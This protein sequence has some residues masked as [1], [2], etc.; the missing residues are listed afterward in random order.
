[1][2]NQKTLLRIKEYLERSR[3]P[4]NKSQVATDLKISNQSV[5]AA[6]YGLQRLG[7]VYFVSN[8]RRSSLIFLNDRRAVSHAE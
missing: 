1:M 3:R 7:V 4:V 2:S 8:G 5:T 6:L